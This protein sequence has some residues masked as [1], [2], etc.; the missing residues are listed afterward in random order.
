[1]K[2]FEDFTCSESIK[3]KDKGFLVINSSDIEALFYCI[4]LFIFIITNELRFV[5]FVIHFIPDKQELHVFKSLKNTK[6]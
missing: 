4:F 2:I 5:V 6:S 1:M 3:Q